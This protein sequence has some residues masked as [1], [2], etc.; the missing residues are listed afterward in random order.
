MSSYN[1]AFAMF[2]DRLTENAE[3]E[4]RSEYISNFFSELGNGGKELIKE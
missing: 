3:Y 1:S 4:V 2:Y